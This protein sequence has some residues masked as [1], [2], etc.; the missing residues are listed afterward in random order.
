MTKG[1]KDWEKL[2]QEKKELPGWGA[3]FSHYGP[4]VGYN[5]DSDDQTLDEVLDLEGFSD[6]ED[7]E[8]PEVTI[9]DTNANMNGQV[10]DSD[11][12]TSSQTDSVGYNIPHQSTEDQIIAR[13]EGEGSYRGRPR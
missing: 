10:A 1:C 8:I 7:P 11:P 13:T 2:Y 5:N 9:T 3:I 6:K 12:S 4:R